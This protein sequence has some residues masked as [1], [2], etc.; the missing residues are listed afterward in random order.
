MMRMYLHDDDANFYD[1]S[2]PNRS[3]TVRKS[4]LLWAIIYWKNLIITWRLR[5][6]QQSFTDA[7]DAARTTINALDRDVQR[8]YFYLRKM[9]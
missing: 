4:D 9:Y 2:L 5:L 8:F 7:N 1:G 6:N 3:D